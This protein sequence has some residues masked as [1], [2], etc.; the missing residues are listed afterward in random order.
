MSRALVRIAGLTARIGGWRIAE[1]AS[2]VEWSDEACELHG[3]PAGTTPTVQAAL[4]FHAA[5]DHDV[6][7][8]TTDRKAPNCSD[9]RVPRA[10]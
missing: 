9:D 8:V 6:V 10:R 1:G 7:G 2:H 5:R 3:E 4:L